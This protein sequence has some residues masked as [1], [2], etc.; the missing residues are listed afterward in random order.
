MARAI[1]DLFLVIGLLIKIPD[2]AAAAKEILKC[3][4]VV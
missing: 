3:G 1:P 2:S 4:I